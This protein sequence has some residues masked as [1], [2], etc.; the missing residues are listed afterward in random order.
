MGGW[1]K[2][3]T[4]REVV[5]V[6]SAVDA[7][8]TVW[9]LSSGQVLSQLRSCAAPRNALTCVGFHFLAAAQVHK[10]SAS[11][12]GGGAVYFWAWHKVCASPSASETRFTRISFGKGLCPVFAISFG[13]SD[14]EQLGLSS[15]RFEWKRVGSRSLQCNVHTLGF[16]RP[17]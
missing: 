2:L 4:V 16:R 13:V 11:S 1:S 5:V 12:A 9:D 15:W 6:C 17:K 10:P 3:A 14:W 8:V 7:G